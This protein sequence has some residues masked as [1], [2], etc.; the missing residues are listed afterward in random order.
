MKRLILIIALLPT[1][2]L[3]EVSVYHGLATTHLFMDNTHLNND[4]GVTAIRVNDIVFGRMKNTYKES[5]YF[6]GYMPKIVD[7][8]RI[9]INLGAMYIE[10]YRRKQVFIYRQTGDLDEHVI[11]VAPSLS[12]S[13][14]ITEG[15]AIQGVLMA[16]FVANAGIRFDF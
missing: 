15:I 9:E 8:G 4:N 12:A 1:L 14:D 6:A 5:G 7:R 3:A 11:V 16:G 10:G 2:A 13:I